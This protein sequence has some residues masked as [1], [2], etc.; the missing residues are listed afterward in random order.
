MGDLPLGAFQLMLKIEKPKTHWLVIVMVVA[1]MLRVATA[2]FLG[3]GLTGSEQVRI[4]DQVSYDALARSLL[5]GDGYSFDK[6]WYPFTPANTP[7]AHWSFIYPLWLAGVYAL[8]GAH[9][10]AVRLLQ[11]GITGVLTT[12]LIYR[13]GGRLFGEMVGLAGAALGSVYAYFVFYDAA[14]MTESFFTLGVLAMLNLGLGLVENSSKEEDNP[15]KRAISRWLL[16]GVVTG[17]TA[18]IRQT[19]LFWVPVMLLWMFWVWADRKSFPWRNAALMI[20]TAAALV[21]P[22][23]ARNHIVYGD[24]LPL[25]SNAGYALYSANHPDH[26]TQFVQDY[27]APLPEDLRS[28]GLNEAEWNTALTRRGLEFVFEDPRRYILLSV[29]RIPIFFHGWFSAESTLAS[30]LMRVLSF[31]LYLPFFLLGIAFSLKYWRHASLIYLFALLFSAMHILTWA[32]VRYRLPVDAA[33]MPFAAL[34]VLSI[35]DRLQKWYR[36]SFQ[37]YNKPSHQISVHPTQENS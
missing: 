37:S 9:P 17:V 29:N 35:A 25:N 15:G 34:A 14:L 20:A 5:A 36:I 18:L 11:A 19:I 28:Q 27:A 3:D 6:P 12:W 8:A 16:L 13:L 7:T 23:T 2:L 30:N 31:G 10:L 32:S 24:F 26:G 33:L 1:V 22:W 21:L 4:W